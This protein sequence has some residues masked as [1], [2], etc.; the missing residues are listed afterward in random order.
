MSKTGLA[1]SSPDVH[2]NG[3]SDSL[4]ELLEL[5]AAQP[6]IQP[7]FL[8]VHIATVTVQAI[9]HTRTGTTLSTRYPLV[10]PRRMRLVPVGLTQMGGCHLLAITRL[11]RT[12]YLAPLT[13]L[14]PWCGYFAS[15]LALS[16]KYSV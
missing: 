6:L 2:R 9:D 15:N 12:Y 4:E 14:V 1:F 13:L 8:L 11:I 3:G 5:G 16:V 10:R 7:V